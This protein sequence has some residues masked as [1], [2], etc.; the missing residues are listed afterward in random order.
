MSLLQVAFAV[1][2]GVAVV[3]G[4]GRLLRTQARHAQSRVVFV[5]RL[6]LQPLLAIG[7]YLVLYPPLRDAT[8][9]ATLTVL[10][11][12]W[13]H[14]VDGTAFDTANTIAL[15]EAGSV[16]GVAADPDLGTAL[17][18]RPDAANLRI[19][20]DGLPDRDRQAA[21]GR[22]IQFHPAAPRLGI[23]ELEGAIELRAGQP[24]TVAG[25]AHGA[26]DGEALLLDPAG[27]VL[28]RA[29]IGPDGRHTL[30]TIA[31]GDGPALLTLQL[32]DGNGDVIESLPIPFVV[33]LP[34]QPRV[35]LLSGAPNPELKYLRRWA[36]DAGID[37]VSRV[38]LTERIAQ[39][40][41]DAAL[42]PDAL[43]A[44]DL[45]IVDERAWFA[46]ADAERSL[47]LDAVQGGLGLL[48]RL[49]D[50]PTPTHRQALQSLGF[51]VT[52]ADLSRT[53]RL[54]GASIHDATQ[55]ERADDAAAPPIDATAASVTASPA[56]I[57]LNRRPLHVRA[58]D[59]AA[60]LSAVNG[61][62]L[63]LWRP[64]GQGRIALWWLGDSFRLV[65]AGAESQHGALWSRAIDALARPRGNPPLRIEPGHPHTGT[66]ATVCGIDDDAYVIAPDSSRTPLLPDPASGCAAFWPAAEGFHRIVASNTAAQWMHAS[67]TGATPALHAAQLQQSTARL[68]EAHPGPLA[69]RRPPG[70][71][72]SPWPFL[73]AWLAL[74]TSAAWLE[75]RRG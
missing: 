63:A 59:G 4:S 8:G 64:L 3:L 39:R 38:Q 69:D 72:A 35:L 24:L 53:A 30:H 21:R 6:L 14:S 61:E 46:L 67:P 15:P 1:L 23:V 51:D 49:T 60:L 73:L 47:L 29:A 13:Q 74:F 70:Q 44:F 25:R 10:T 65:L 33:T 7:L 27:N 56:D 18:R 71:P 55:R 40:R 11:A 50:D 58:D 16:P 9:D 5:L 75:R 12:R 32:T 42:D 54:A 52:G 43:Q 48:L 57:A 62:P 2:L 20:G 37:L 66:R 19:L 68:A 28:D 31:R 34:D 26:D 17:R 36:L 45:A 22:S 41:G